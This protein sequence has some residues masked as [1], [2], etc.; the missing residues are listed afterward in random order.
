MSNF[1]LKKTTRTTL[2]INQEI[3]VGF[4]GFSPHSV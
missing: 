1:Y 3:V 4:E 2:V